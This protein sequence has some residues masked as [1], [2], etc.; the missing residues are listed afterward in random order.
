[1]HAHVDTLK[2]N[3]TQ[4]ASNSVRQKKGDG[5]QGIGFVDN[6]PEVVAQR[7]RQERENNE[8]RVSLSGVFPDAADA[9]INSSLQ[10]KD[11]NETSQTSALIDKTNT[12]QR[13]VKETTS[14]SFYSDITQ[15]FYE[16]RQ[17]AEVAEEEVLSASD[18]EEFVDDNALILGDEEVGRLK[19]KREAGILSESKKIKKRSSAFTVELSHRRNKW[20]ERL[21]RRDQKSSQALKKRAKRVNSVGRHSMLMHTHTAPPNMSVSGSNPWEQSKDV[22]P[23]SSAFNYFRTGANKQSSYMLDG[24]RK[25]FVFI[26]EM[27]AFYREFYPDDK[28]V[29]FVNSTRPQIDG[30]MMANMAGGKYHDNGFG[31]EINAYAKSRLVPDLATKKLDREVKTYGP[32][33]K[34]KEY[35]PPDYTS[36]AVKEFMD[37]K[38]GNPAFDQS[39]QSQLLQHCR[40]IVEELAGSLKGLK[41]YKVVLRELGSGFITY[42]SL[43][44][45]PVSVL[46]LTRETVKP[47][48]YA[49]IS[50][51]NKISKIKMYE[52]GSFG[53][54]YPTISDLERSIRIWPGQ[55]DLDYF[56]NI[57]VKVMTTLDDG[58]QQEKLWHRQDNEH[59][60]EIP[61]SG[62][63]T[64]Q[65]LYNTLDRSMIFVKNIY[66]DLGTDYDKNDPA[67]K[68][69]HNRLISN[70]DK[71]SE[72]KEMKRTGQNS[73]IMNVADEYLEATQVID[74]LNEYG[75]QLIEERLR[76]TGEGG[77][78]DTGTNIIGTVRESFASAITEGGFTLRQATLTHSGMQAGMLAIRERK[79]S[80]FHLGPSYFEFDV[81]RLNNSE[82]FVKTKGV[83]TTGHYDPAYNFTGSDEFDKKVGTTEGTQH[84]DAQKIMDITNVKPDEISDILKRHQE[85]E[86]I[87]F[88]GSL[89]KHFQLGMDRTTLGILMVVDNNSNKE[90][91]PEANF[92]DLKI[93]VEL[94]KYY[95]LMQKTQNP[96]H[97]KE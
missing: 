71:A 41:N 55:V 46:R 22:Q 26:P 57:M 14:G 6:R 25:F 79:T 30:Y 8:E 95:T 11:K 18:I 17:E 39:Y 97:S 74:N 15:Q 47:Y 85:C 16:T 32:P 73:L 4:A 9:M 24:R 77:K 3:K 83:G 88:Y 60:S 48:M 43:I 7:E 56:K 35:L 38:A 63:T 82:F 87:Y 90:P 70:M 61:V 21:A 62:Q 68:Y 12:V 66:E 64:N 42:P 33:L 28:T 34:S 89:S 69:L 2:I 80:V 65:T 19:R 37:Q 93:P 76:L 40:K 27:Y 94:I 49:I 84:K 13:V 1:M 36:V 10:R 78:T 75:F 59:L 20:K 58:K 86:R 53:F 51:F 45:E 67:I 81:G 54:L 31:S 50:Q 92:P 23:G 96:S 44:L 29:E 5:K 52:R 91:L 72:L